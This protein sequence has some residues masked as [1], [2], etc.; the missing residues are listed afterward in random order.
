M[1]LGILYH[2]PFWQT[3][4]GGLWEAE[5]SFA[6]YVDS[7]APYFDRIILSVPVFDVPPATGTRVRATNVR[8]APL[9]YFPG[10]RQFYPNLPQVYTRLKRWVDQCD[11]IHL[12]VPTPAGVFAHRLARER[13]KPVFLL[14]VGDYRAL[15][16]HLPYRGVKKLLFSAYVAF[17][18]RALKGMIRRSLTFVNGAALR[19]KHASRHARTPVRAR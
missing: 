15:A 16:P 8:L 18:E 4:D 9:P 5:G 19:A 7:L 2:M 12:R 3:P 14:V 1:R 6:R 13:N 17:E 10:P 11:V